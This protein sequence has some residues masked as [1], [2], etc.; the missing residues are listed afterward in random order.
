MEVLQ[1]EGQEKDLVVS[2]GSSAELHCYAI[3]YPFPQVT[4]WKD[5]SMVPLN[6]NELVI[7]KDY[8]LLIHS[9][10]LSNLGIY[11]CQAYNGV[12][13]A[14]SW[15]VTLKTLGPVYTTNPEDEKYMPFVVNAPEAPVT[16]KPTYPY[17]PG[18]A[19][20]APVEENEV[21]PQPQRQPEQPI[22]NGNLHA[23]STNFQCILS[24]YIFL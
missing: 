7:R 23:N 16:E 11:T 14:V 12:G 6:T 13:K 3:G 24:F 20:V 22:Y 2:L 15:T 1:V 21:V 9:V 4:W 18:R 19:T 5:R 10:K 17:R 8:S